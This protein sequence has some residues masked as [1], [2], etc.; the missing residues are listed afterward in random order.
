V[1]PIW[2]WVFV[3][4]WAVASGVVV[5]RTVARRRALQALDRE[6]QGTGSADP[7]AVHVV[8]RVEP[9][10]GHSFAITSR[11]GRSRTN[12]P[13]ASASAHADSVQKV[14]ATGCARRL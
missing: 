6:V 11:W 1:L 10:C 13:N 4:G 2:T 8:N 12:A 7:G 14:P 3:V 9:M 5:R